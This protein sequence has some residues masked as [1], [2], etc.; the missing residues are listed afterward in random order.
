MKPV[1]FI[2]G[3]A[4]DC[5][6]FDDICL[7]PGYHKI[8]LEWQPAAGD[9][10]MSYAARTAAQIAQDAIL[11]GMSFGGM[12]S[13]EIARL[14]PDIMVILISSSPRRMDL[15]FYFR[16][17]LASRVYYGASRP[18]MRLFV[19]LLRTYLKCHRVDPIITGKIAAM[20][21]NTDIG[22]FKWSLDSMRTWDSTVIPP[23][24]IR[25]HGT[26]DIILPPGYIKGHVD[27]WVSGGG[28]LMVA[29]ENRAVSVLLQGVIGER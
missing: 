3:L 8:Y 29:V 14:R 26:R 13:T 11:I 5:S 15:P 4:A 19:P 1:Y 10:I 28:H 6:L 7:P 18:F 23:N 9:D 12:V 24:I 27:Q 20:I 21:R 22:L 16:W 2:S 25:M 17:L